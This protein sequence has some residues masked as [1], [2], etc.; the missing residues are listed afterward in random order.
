MKSINEEKTP[1][2]SEDSSHNSSQFNVTVFL[3][4]SD[5]K[6]VCKFGDQIRQGVSSGHYMW[7]VCNKAHR[8]MEVLNLTGSVYLETISSLDEKITKLPQ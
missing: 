7:H 6:S 3:T 1:K 8:V 2:V 4:K 5:F